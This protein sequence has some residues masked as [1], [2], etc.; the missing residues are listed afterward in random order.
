M[1]QERVIR[2]TVRRLATLVAA[3]AAG[4]DKGIPAYA[5]GQP[6]QL[7]S[8][9]APE[10]TKFS[11]ALQG[12]VAWA[13]AAGDAGVNSASALPAYSPTQALF[14]AGLLREHDGLLQ[15]YVHVDGE[16]DD[17]LRDALTNA[18]ATL[19]IESDE[20]GIVQISV[21][22]AALGSLADIDG[23]RA[24][25][26]PSYGVVNVGGNLTEGDALLSYDDLRAVQGVNGTGAT[27]GMISDDIGGL[28]TAVA[29]GD[30]PA[31]SEVRDGEGVL[32]ATTGGVI[33]TSFRFNGDLEAGLGASS[34]CRAV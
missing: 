6:P 17:G 14:A 5:P 2:F 28:Q 32:T 9:R 34:V 26:E 11:G 7:G 33:S 10:S 1:A 18:G 8:D 13:D 31:T 25:T 23:V 15:V 20:Q 16:I 29:S 3:L 4:G 30:L 27:V 21:P 12:V 22:Y 19:E 24:I